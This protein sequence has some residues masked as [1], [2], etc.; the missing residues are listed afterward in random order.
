[1]VSSFCS[2]RSWGLMLYFAPFAR[3]ITSHVRLFAARSRL[4]GGYRVRALDVGGAGTPDGTNPLS[5]GCPQ[6]NSARETKII[7]MCRKS[8][9]CSASGPRTKIVRPMRTPAIVK[10]CQMHG[11]HKRLMAVCPAECTFILLDRSLPEGAG[12][13]WRNHTGW[14]QAEGSRA[15][16]GTL[17]YA[18]MCGDVN[19]YLNDPDDCHCAEVEVHIQ[20]HAHAASLCMGAELQS[21]GCC[22]S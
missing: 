11:R 9:T 21:Q 1:M 8:W 5:H 7:C 18:G 12:G 3:K 16:R 22:R 2:R 13:C 4:E 15:D 17:L 14:R 19:L 6:T 10:M 20:L